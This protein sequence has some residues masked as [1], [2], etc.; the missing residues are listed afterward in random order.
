MDKA[1]I[2]NFEDFTNNTKVKIENRKIEFAN[3]VKNLNETKLDILF[4]QLKIVNNAYFIHD[5]K[6]Y[7][8]KI[9]SIEEIE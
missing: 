4:E 8:Q 1:K 2:K 6:P 9:L 7:V 5:G 3:N